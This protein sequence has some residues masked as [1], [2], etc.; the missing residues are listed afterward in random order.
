MFFFRI[1]RLNRKGVFLLMWSI[2]IVEFVLLC[3]LGWL[4]AKFAFHS[5]WVSSYIEVAFALNVAISSK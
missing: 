2:G 3:V 4:S 5:D 1:A